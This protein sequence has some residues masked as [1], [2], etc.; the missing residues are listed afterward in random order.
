MKKYRSIFLLFSLCA[1]ALN[2]EVTLPR[3]LSD[4]MVLQRD[5]AVALWGWADSGESVSVSFA[6]QVKTTVAASAGEWKLY[7]DPLEASKEPRELVIRVP[8]DEAKTPVIALEIDEDGEPTRVYRAKWHNLPNMRRLIFVRAAN[9][10]ET[11]SVW[12][13]IIEDFAQKE[14]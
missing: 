2:A 1:A 11:G 12:G 13:R 9:D 4:H 7:L 6:G 14:I 3:V 10:N 5:R 8:K